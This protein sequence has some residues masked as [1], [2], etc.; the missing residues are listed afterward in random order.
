MEGTR[1]YGDDDA[2]YRRERRRKDEKMG[3]YTQDAVI[4]LVE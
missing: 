4:T 3:I 1:K 2:V